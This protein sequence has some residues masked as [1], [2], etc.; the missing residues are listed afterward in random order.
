M[1]QS[2]DEGAL[3]WFQ[4]D[5]LMEVW[6]YF[7]ASMLCSPHN[8]SIFQTRRAEPRLGDSRT[9]SRTCSA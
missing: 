1:A 3:L 4:P 6:V 5:P 9:I 8:G 7:G 2:R